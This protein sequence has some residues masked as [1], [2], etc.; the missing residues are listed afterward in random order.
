MGWNTQYRDS[1]I[2]TEKNLSDEFEELTSGTLFSLARL[3]TAKSNNASYKFF[4]IHPVEG[5]YSKYEVFFFYLRC[6]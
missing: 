2:I 3:P 5:N 6:C 1:F 4:Q